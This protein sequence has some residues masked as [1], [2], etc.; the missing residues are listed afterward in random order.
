M[1]LT[2]STLVMAEVISSQQPQ[3]MGNRCTLFKNHAIASSIFFSLA[4]TMPYLW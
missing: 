3:F 1:G 4:N 2:I